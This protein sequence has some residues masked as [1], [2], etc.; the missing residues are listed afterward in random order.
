MSKIKCD[1][2]DSTDAKIIQPITVIWNNKPLCFDY[3]EE[4][5]KEDIQKGF[6]VFNEE[7]KKFVYIPEQ[8]YLE[9]AKTD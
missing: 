1:G 5:I 2:C 7:G 4:C 8:F 3:C 6:T 9:D